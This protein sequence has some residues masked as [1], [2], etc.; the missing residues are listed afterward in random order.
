M[1]R[2]RM[3]LVLAILLVVLCSSL[4]GGLRWQR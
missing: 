4:G 2:H 1:P 3:V